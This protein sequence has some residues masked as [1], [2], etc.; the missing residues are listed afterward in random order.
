M[1]AAA[2]GRRLPFSDV[3]DAMSLYVCFALNA[4]DVCDYRSRL[5]LTK[6]RTDDVRFL[7]LAERKPEVVSRGAP[8]QGTRHN[9]QLRIGSSYRKPEVPIHTRFLGGGL[10]K[11]LDMAK[12][13][14]LILAPLVEKQKCDDML[15]Q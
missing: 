3:F 13:A 12:G 7:S 1:S 8:L 14:G 2:S 9:S 10:L 15:H 4:S 5:V 6:C 11:M